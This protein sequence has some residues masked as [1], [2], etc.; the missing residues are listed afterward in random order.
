MGDSKKIK[1]FPDISVKLKAPAKKSLFERQKAE[2]EAKKQREEAENAAALQDFEKAFGVDDDEDDD[3]P[4]SLSSRGGFGRGAPPGPTR[5]GFGGGPARHFS[6]S[7]TRLSGPGSLGPAPI[8]PKKRGYDGGSRESD[9]DREKGVLKF[10]N[11]SKGPLSAAAAF[12]V[13]DDEEEPEEKAVE[14]A[15]PKPTMLLTQLPPGYSVASIKALIP[16]SLKIDSVRTMPPTGPS[17]DRRSLSAIVTLARETPASEIDTTVAALQKRYLG[18]GYYL[19][20][21]RHLSSATLNSMSSSSTGLGTVIGSLPFG[22]KTAPPSGPGH[23]LNRAPPPTRGGYAPPPT[24]GPSVG[25]GRG[26]SQQ[27]VVHVTQPLKI[28]QLRLIHKT[29]ENVLSAGA[30]FESLLMSRPEVRKS[31]KWAFLFDARSPE[32]RYYRS[33][34][35]SIASGST[36]NKGNSNDRDTPKSIFH[37]S[38][39]WQ[40]PEKELPF[41]FTTAINEFVSDSGFESESEDSDNESGRLPRREG[42]LEETEVNYLNPLYRAELTFLLRRL[43]PTTGKLRR[44]DIAAIMAFAIKHAAG[45]EEVV[46]IIVSNVEK[47]F[48][49]S[50]AKAESKDASDSDAAKGPQ[51]QQPE[52]EDDSSPRLIGLYVISDILSSCA[53]SGVRLAWRYR[54]LFESALRTRGTFAKLGRLERERGWGRLRAEKWKRC[55]K[56]VFRTWEGWSVFPH[57]TMR[58]FEEGFLNPPLTGRE[59]E[60]VER[61]ERERERVEGEKRKARE[62]LKMRIA[63]ASGNE[64]VE[65][66]G[67]GPGRESG[68]GVPM[69]EDEDV[70]GVPML[71]EDID[72]EP[73]P[74]EDIDGEPM[75]EDS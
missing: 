16:S 72:G 69:V 7:T 18:D 29:I 65:G 60:V 17:T 45:G 27:Q 1:E 28:E 49:Q 58:E 35:H 54:Q 4:L 66:G 62:A 64:G 67:E 12:A 74:E 31:E 20:L 52:L 59:R 53:T 3:F 25:Y 63:A 34:L 73:M 5:G 51:Q 75:E 37:D 15:A 11:S 14:K 9:R 47:P 26:Q 33:R 10:S 36:L 48:N 56:E 39:P 19:S 57:T 32:G 43:P 6:A 30:E 61:A 21:S 70:N 50:I 13:S 2:A 55:V 42:G 8:L 44:R 23:S 24:Y 38:A 22:A 41:E 40:P 68:N 46:N 71:D